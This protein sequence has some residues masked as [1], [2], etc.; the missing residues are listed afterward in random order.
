MGRTKEKPWKA[1]SRLGKKFLL[2]TW[3][4]E[5]YSPEGEREEPFRKSRCR[6]GTSES[7]KNPTDSRRVILEERK[8]NYLY[9]L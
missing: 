1:L 7:Y 5:D 2:R 3:A 9:I 8:E 4:Q 6:I